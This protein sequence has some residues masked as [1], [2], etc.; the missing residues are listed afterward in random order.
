M[1]WPDK[2]TMKKNPF[3]EGLQNYRDFMHT[4]FRFN[5]RNSL[6]ILAVMVVFPAFI[7]WGSLATDAKKVE[8]FK[9]DFPHLVVKTV[10]QRRA[11]ER[12]KE[13]EEQRKKAKE[14]GEE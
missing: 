3:I 2:Y 9:R 1:P 14:E 10:A 13:E 4:E 11:E 6:P 7:V 8:V 5:S 12:V